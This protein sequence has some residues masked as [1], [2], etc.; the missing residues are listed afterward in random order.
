[1]DATF[2]VPIRNLFCLLS[3]VNEM[4]EFI[5]R[6][7]DVDEDLITYDFLA[8]RFNY[9]VEKLLDR[10]VIRNYVSHI[11]ETGF[12]AG[13]MM[14]NESIHLVM[15]RKPVVVCEK[16]EYSANILMNQMMKT[17]LRG[18]IHNRNV[19]EKTRNQCFLLWERLPTVHEIPL[20]R[21][22][23]NR[24]TFYRHD[25]HYKPMIHMARL[26]HELTL[27]SHKRGDW[28]LF[29]VDLKESELNRLFEKFLFQFF[30]KEQ[31]E[32]RVHSE[33]LHW[34]LQGNDALLPTMLT[35]VSLTHHTKHEKII[36][37]AKFYRHMFQRHYDKKTFHSHN[38]Y[39]MFTY[40][41]HQPQSHRVRGIL[42]YPKNQVE[43]IY[44]VYSRDERISLEVASLDLN[45]AWNEIHEKLLSLLD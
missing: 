34:D 16:D 31:R 12:I 32:Y 4:P 9:E 38:L 1:M 10:G 5:D 19:Q 14:M 8:T 7:S 3:Y 22:V 45:A 36:I 30:K 25:A 20:T 21:E 24:L 42:I 23:F 26:L 18:L 40:V 17:T 44:E 13:R 39:Q 35:D 29:T 6:L 11:E 37:D 28:S 15:E 2:K 33:R 41:M 27:L 43:D